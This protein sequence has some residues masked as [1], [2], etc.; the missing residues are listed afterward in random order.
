MRY[1]EPRRPTEYPAELLFCG[2]PYKVEIREVSSK[3]LKISGLTEDV[4][5]AAETG[6]ELTLNILNHRIPCRLRW[7]EGG[8]AG[9]ELALPLPK[10][11][12]EKVRRRLAGALSGRRFG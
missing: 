6:A 8:L 10:A 4:S 7:R 1:R 2:N 9:L 3:G 5:A 11:V 12:D